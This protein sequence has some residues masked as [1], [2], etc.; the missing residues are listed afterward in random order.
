MHLGPIATQSVTDFLLPSPEAKEWKLS[1][2]ALRMQKE[3]MSLAYGE[4]GKEP[5]LEHKWRKSLCPIS[6][7]WRKMGRVPS[8][9]TS[10]QRSVEICQRSSMQVYQDRHIFLSSPGT[11]ENVFSTWIL[12]LD[13]LAGLL[14]INGST[15]T[16]WP[17]WDWTVAQIFHW[18]SS[19]TFPCIAITGM[20]TLS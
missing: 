4:G 10:N 2:H 11:G 19:S 1:A 9:G 16:T 17:V 7:S 8:L 5:F 20:S 15:N 12:T 6:K 14:K 13:S 3:K 18:H